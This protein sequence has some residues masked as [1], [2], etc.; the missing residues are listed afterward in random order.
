MWYGK[1]FYKLGVQGFGLFSHLFGIFFAKY[2]SSKKVLC[3]II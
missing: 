3:L 2:G 1:A